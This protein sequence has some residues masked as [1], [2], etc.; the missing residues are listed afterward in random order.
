MKNSKTKGL[1]SLLIAIAAVVVFGILGYTTMDDIKLGLD[2]AGGVSITYQAV[3]E[4]PSAE[5]MSDTAYKLQQRVQNYSTEAEVYQE[6]NNRINIDIPGVS[7]ANA[8]LEELGKP[9]SLVFS[10][11]EGHTILTGVDVISA[12]AGIYR[13]STT[14]MD[15]YVVSLTFNEAG[16]QAFAEA[17]RENIGN[18]IYI[19]YDN[20]VVS[21]PLVNSEITQ[22]SCQITGLDSYETAENLAS[23]I[24]IGSLS[25]ELEELRSNV[26]GAKL[27]ETAITSSLMA[28]A[29]GFAI[30]AVFMIAVYLIP[31]LAATIALCLYVGLILILL[32]AFEITLTLPGV[33]GI[34]LSIGMAV[35]AN[36]IIFTRIKEEIGVGK[37]VKSAI[38]TGFQKALS[39]IIDG[40]VTTIIAAVVLYWRGSGTVKGFASTLAL[41]ILLSMFTALFVTRFILNAFYNMGLDK[42]KMYGIKKERAPINFLGKRNICFAISLVVIVAGFVVAPQGSSSSYS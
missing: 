7:D 41:G 19:I 13:D 8:I 36:V 34:I 30:V 16:T 4:N 25:L 29:V 31:G 17:T 5:D 2:L 18:P 40:N 39:A 10:D 11:Q 21:S 28:G 26:V 23:T 6:G 15:E 20:Q 35:D 9:G 22:G 14:G 1:I 42:P 37:T 12:Q 24:R 27:G 32:S 38:K 3:E 33:A